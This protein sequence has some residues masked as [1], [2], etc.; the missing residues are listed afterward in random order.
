MKDALLSTGAV[1]MDTQP[2]LVII[3][4]RIYKHTNEY[5]PGKLDKASGPYRCRDPD[6]E[7]FLL[8]LR[9]KKSD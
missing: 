6:G 1:V 4:N 5:K 7:E 9:G 8:W 3:E 2:I